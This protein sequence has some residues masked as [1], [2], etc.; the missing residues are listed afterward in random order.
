M[1]KSRIV[2]K[3]RRVKRTPYEERVARKLA[4]RPITRPEVDG[5][6]PRVKPRY[7]S[8]AVGTHFYDVDSDSAYINDNG[9]ARLPGCVNTKNTAKMLHPEKRFSPDGRGSADGE[10]APGQTR[11][12]VYASQLKVNNLY[13]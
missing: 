2:G 13:K 7:D 10:F 12:A 11:P 8:H 3:T 4:R 6:S 9:T 1:T 5:C